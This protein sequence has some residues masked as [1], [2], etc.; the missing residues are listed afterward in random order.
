MNHTEIIEKFL[1]GE[2]SP[3]EQ[4]EFSKW[5]ETDPLLREELELQQ[6][7][8]SGM[9]RVALKNEISHAFKKIRLHRMI[10]MGGFAGII[11]LIVAALTVMNFRSTELSPVKANSIPGFSRE[12][13]SVHSVN[14]SE[15]KQGPQQEN[16]LTFAGGDT[17]QKNNPPRP[18]NANAYIFGSRKDKIVAEE[19][20][21]PSG[22]FPTLRLFRVWPGKDTSIKLT[23]AGTVL[24]VPANAFTA[25]NGTNV[26]DTVIISY[27]EYANSA[28]IAFSGIPMTY[29]ENGM[30]YNFNSSGMF[31][32][33]GESQGE[34]VEIKKELSVDYALARQNPDIDFYYLD[35]K[36]NEWVKKQEIEKLKIRREDPFAGGAKAMEE[37]KKKDSLMDAHIRMHKENGTWP[38]NHRD[39]VRARRKFGENWAGV[40]LNEKGTGLKPLSP[41]NFGLTEKQVM[42][43]EMNRVNFNFPK[44]RQDTL[45]LKEKLG[46]DWEEI[47]FVAQKIKFIGDSINKAKINNVI[48]EGG[49]FYV[50]ENNK[51]EI[52]PSTLLAEGSSDP[53]H[54]YPAIIRGLNI[55][56]F[57]VYNCDQIYRVGNPVTV[58]PK[59]LDKAGKEIK[60]AHVLSMID[61]NY[62]GAFSFSPK[63]F[64]CNPQANNVLLLFT[65]SGKLF[66]LPKDAFRA[67]SIGK[68]GAYDFLMTDV[69][70]EIKSAGDLRKYLGLK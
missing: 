1:N 28:E 31:E 36:T 18:Y 63:S 44:S 54:T 48:I 47:L 38:K 4:Q 56:S 58:T 52:K 23:A 20:R 8:L 37:K 9:E 2:M 10:R 25:K 34:P 30:E 13:G 3:E 60:D 49:R 62:N 46:E 5:L 6:E 11:I 39:S 43:Y 66:I 45:R 59:F 57:G 67:M 7:I 35:K 29:R 32:I 41:N 69:T 68:N 24:H 61:L 21:I 51:V 15:I 33:E 65:K 16:D 42:M 17:L 12:K 53:G 50:L 40:F 19:F 26:K 14:A 64:T 27:R 22:F 55:R 70:G